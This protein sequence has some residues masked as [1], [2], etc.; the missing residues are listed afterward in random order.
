MKNRNLDNVDDWA[1][2]DYFYKL[3][4]EEF[5]FNFDPCPLQHNIAEWDGLE[6]EK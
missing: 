6:V 3:L 5:N 1:T 2:P 4:N